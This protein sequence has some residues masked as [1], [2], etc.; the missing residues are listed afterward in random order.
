MEFDLLLV[1]EL[2]GSIAFAISGAT[3]AIQEK[4]DLL[5]ICILGMT[6]AVG[7]GIIR[8]IVLGATPPLA[9][10]NPVYAITALVTSLIVFLINRKK[11]G[12]MEG[13]LFWLAD[14]VGLAVFTTVGA[15]AGI[16]KE[17]FFLIIFLGCITGVGGGVLRDIF[18]NRTPVI[19]QKNIYATA[20]L[21]GA[22]VFALLFKYDRYAAAFIGE[23][24]IIVLRF[25]AVK[26]NWTLPKVK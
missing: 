15:A 19:F 21:I 10:Y 7:G 2:I 6:T 25:F 5:G 18:A 9:F 13:W 1:L 16:Y 23:A 24:V 8:D 4:M 11:E 12:D 22:I 17:S 3:V 20:S 14:S 26:F